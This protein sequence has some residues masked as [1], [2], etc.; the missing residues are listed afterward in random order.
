ML[1]G[2]LG[3]DF[4]SG[5][6]GG[7]HLNGGDGNDKLVGG[8]GSDTIEGGAGDDHLWGGDWWKDGASDTFVISSGGGKD[9]IHDF[10]TGVDQIDLS[11]YGLE[12]SD[13][14]SLMTDKG[15]ATEIDL[16]GLDGANQNDKLIIKSVDPDDLDEDTFIL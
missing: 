8:K 12:F 11:S 4:L 9:M 5:G 15:W 1:F 16:S 7:D 13:L 10:E 2:G 6:A 3:T 14:K